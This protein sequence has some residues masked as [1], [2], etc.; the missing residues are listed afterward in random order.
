MFPESIST[1]LCQFVP[2][3]MPFFF[4]L[5]SSQRSILMV[6]LFKIPIS[7]DNVQNDWL[8]LVCVDLLFDIRIACIKNHLFQI[9]LVKQLGPFLRCREFQRSIFFHCYEKRVDVQKRVRRF[10]ISVKNGIPMNYTNSNFPNMPRCLM[11]TYQ[12]ASFVPFF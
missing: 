6:V 12:S 5:L 7:K 4:A 3:S 8:H 10:R 1:S 11:T 2:F 9:F